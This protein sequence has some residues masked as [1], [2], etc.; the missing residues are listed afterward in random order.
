MVYTFVSCMAVG[1]CKGARTCSQPM[2]VCGRRSL[3]SVNSKV[4]CWSGSPAPAWATL[5]MLWAELGWLPA[6]G[7]GVRQGRLPWGRVLRQ[8]SCHSQRRPGENSCRERLR[9]PGPAPSGACGVPAG[10]LARSPFFG[11]L[12]ALQSFL[13]FFLYLFSPLSLPFPLTTFGLSWLCGVDSWVLAFSSFSP[14][15]VSPSARPAHPL[16]LPSPFIRS[17]PALLLIL[18]V[19]FSCIY[20]GCPAGQAQR[21]TQNAPARMC[22]ADP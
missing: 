10:C 21:A 14:L 4:A 2:P 20:P 8:A 15:P 18:L 22:D 13:L 12:P 1:F 19:S 17:C 11:H 7:R 3:L 6:R 9:S 5:P 16:L